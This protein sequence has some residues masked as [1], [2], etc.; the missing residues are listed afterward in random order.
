MTYEFVGS[1]RSVIL[2]LIPTIVIVMAAV[3]APW[4]APENP[5]LPNLKHRLEPPSRTYPFGTDQLGRCVFSRVIHGARI[6][7]GGAVAAS[8][9]SLLLG[10]LLGMAAALGNRPIKWMINSLIDMAL[11]LP[12]LIPALILAGLMGPSMQSLIIGLVIAT[13]PW[14]ARLVRGLTLSAWNRE[15]VLAG[16]VAG[17]TAGRLFNNYLIPQLQGQILA[18]AA[19]KTGWIILAFSGLS[20]LGLGPAP[21]APEWGSMLQQ[22]AIYMTRAPWL[23]LFPGG[24]VTAT[25]LAFNIFG[26]TLNRTVAS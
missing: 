26:E 19:L 21:P 20:Y 9:L 2:A 4:I 8:F 13:W 25:V 10:S 7:V 24:A 15:F 17:L 16:R 23:M 18:A 1:R 22:S 11:A 12:G 6:S 14:W 5:M 3:L